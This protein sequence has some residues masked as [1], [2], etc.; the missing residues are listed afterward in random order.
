MR[1]DA[2]DFFPQR[3]CCILSIYSLPTKLFP[4]EAHSDF[5]V[6][7]DSLCVLNIN[8]NNIDEMLDLAVLNKLTHLYAADNQLEDIQV[9]LH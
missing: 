6:L 1:V 8:S 7:Q 2:A 3:G 9:M 4:R 5:F